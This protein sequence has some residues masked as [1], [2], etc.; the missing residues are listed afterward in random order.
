MIVKYG[1]VK[2]KTLKTV[3][4]LNLIDTLFLLDVTDDKCV[5]IR[6]SNES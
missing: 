2:I 5:Q 1:P 6:G 4:M 3:S